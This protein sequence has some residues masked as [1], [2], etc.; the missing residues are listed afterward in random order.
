[1]T[2]LGVKWHRAPRKAK[3]RHLNAEPINMLT[4]VNTEA[5]AQRMGHTMMHCYTCD[6]SWWEPN[7][8]LRELGIL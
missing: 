2:L 3:C 8:N 1:M 4:S 5:T 7:A 6:A